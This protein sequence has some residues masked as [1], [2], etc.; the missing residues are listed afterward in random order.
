MSLIKNEIILLLKKKL[1]I[2]SQIIGERPFK[3]G[4]IVDYNALGRTI[5]TKCKS[6]LFSDSKNMRFLHKQKLRSVTQNNWDKL[7]PEKRGEIVTRSKGDRIEIEEIHYHI[8]TDPDSLKKIF[9]GESKIHSS[10]THHTV[11]WCFG[12][13]CWED[14]IEHSLEATLEKLRTKYSAK[15]GNSILVDEI[16]KL[17][18]T[19]KAV[20]IVQLHD[21]SKLE[22]GVPLPQTQEEYRKKNQNAGTPE[23]LEGIETSF[24]HRLR[25]G[26]KRYFESH[27]SKLNITDI[28]IP[29]WK[30][31]IIVTGIKTEG[32]DEEKT[33]IKS[34]ENLWKGEKKNILL[35]GEGG[36]GKTFSLVQIWKHYLSHQD[37]NS[38]IPVYVS[39]NRYND[40]PEED[41]DAFI[42]NYILENYLQK[43]FFS[44]EEQ[45][46]LWDVLMDDTKIHAKESPSIILLLDG[47]NEITVNQKNIRKDMDDWWFSK[48]RNV[49]III[50]SRYDMRFD[51]RW[52]DLLKIQLQPLSINAIS[53]YLVKFKILAPKDDELLEL[54]SNPMMLSLYASTS[55]I[56]DKYKSY[57]KFAFK[58]E[59][60]SQGE[61][62]WNFFESQLAKYFETIRYDETN[63]MYYSFLIKHV[64]PFIG[65]NMEKDGLYSI[66]ENKLVDIVNS[67]CID[68]Y[69]E[70]FE[71]AFPMYREHIARFDL[72]EKQ[73]PYIGVRFKA[74]VEILC[75]KLQIIIEENHSYRFLHQNF[76]DFSANVH[77]INEMK[78]AT[79]QKV[80]SP[81]LKERPLNKL[82]MKYI[83]E[84]EGEHKKKEVFNKKKELWENPDT[85]ENALSRQLDV[86]RG[87][88]DES[89]TGYA[90]RNIIKTIQNS[91]GEL[92]GVNMSN[93]NLY[94][95]SFY[96]IRC[97]RKSDSGT[98]ASCFDSSLVREEN[99]STEGLHSGSVNSIAYSPDGTKFVSGS[100]DK[101]VKEWLS[102]TGEC[103]RTFEGHSLA[104]Y[105]VA[106]SSDGTRILSTAAFYIFEFDLKTGRRIEYISNS[107]LTC[108]AYSP[109]DQSF[110]CVDQEGTLTIWAVGKP[111]AMSRIV[112]KE[113]QKIEVVRY[114]A[115]GSEIVTHSESGVIKRWQI[116]SKE[117]VET[118]T[119]A[120][121]ST[122][123]TA[124]RPDFKTRLITNGL[125]I[126]EYEVGS[127]KQIMVYKADSSILSLAYSPDGKKVVAGLFQGEII[128]WDTDSGKVLTQSLRFTS[129]VKNA[130][131]NFNSDRII[132]CFDNNLIK[133]WLLKSGKCINTYSY[134]WTYSEPSIA[135]SN[136][137]SRFSV[138]IEEQ[139]I[140]YS[141]KTGE[142]L[143]KYS[144]MS[145]SIICLAYSHDGE[146]LVA[147]SSRESRVWDTSTGK[148]LPLYENALLKVRYIDFSPSG[149]RFCTV[150]AN[151][152]ILHEWD[153]KSGELIRKYEGEF[154]HLIKIKYHR[155]G[156]TLLGLAKNNKICKWDVSTGEPQ[157]PY[158]NPRTFRTANI[159][160]TFRD[161][162]THMDICN[163]GDRLLGYGPNYPIFEEFSNSGSFFLVNRIPVDPGLLVN[164]CSFHNLHPDSKISDKLKKTLLRNEALFE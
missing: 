39:L 111:Y 53:Q 71:M 31:E 153:T 43:R 20:D 116:S 38:P 135:Y 55:E 72:G 117:C 81:L 40:I 32:E 15:G 94:G 78:L 100:Y 27:Y 92:V 89:I 103:L 77:Q 79:E 139:V 146:K 134:S 64:I 122:Q 35:I 33:L 13:E 105:S 120:K 148:V 85:N 158:D 23:H 50:S 107:T 114:S 113:R 18:N 34:V 19:Y 76:R 10:K 162:N 132:A 47:F 75:N 88:F 109:D 74:I 83:G 87:I 133:E 161:I 150:P 25:E 42:T 68:L 97:F 48:A 80:I 73:F 115:D 157:P 69:S 136:D 140:E 54:L 65:F 16:T 160:D 108:C 129:T 151:R 51:Y 22:E 99:F 4:E 141:T 59:F 91:R 36:M 119:I 93:L 5:E 142:I 49:Q 52:L 90:V 45:K 29:K 57:P 163:D 1:E 84:I 110:V 2:D 28:L 56:I 95:N 21:A 11:A 118:F 9:R 164:G 8:T 106:Y 66:H 3:S 102:D 82:D 70:N 62:M 112:D 137:D 17:L 41:R 123:R 61:L 128:Q 58:P 130:I 125:E 44:S 124:F 96:G 37:K 101:T 104:L 63:F 46:K 12:F 147:L 67:A 7:F 98:L 155:D 159:F 131:Y 152:N 121:S 156:E 154:P 126:I 149:D 86:M 24:L 144:D 138:S 26:S 6:V 60:N 143:H 14:F 30:Q 145:S 127:D